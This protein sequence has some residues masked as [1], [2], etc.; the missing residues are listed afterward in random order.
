MTDIAVRQPAPALRPF[1]RQYA[2]FQ[3]APGPVGTHIGLPSSDVDLI[4]S[5]GK[6]INVVRMPNTS[7]RPASFQALVSGLQEMPALVRGGEA[8]GIHVFIKPLA[9][10]AILG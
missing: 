2:G 3:S 10:Q 5:L 8:F 4:I 1:I 6:P 9:I 7:Q